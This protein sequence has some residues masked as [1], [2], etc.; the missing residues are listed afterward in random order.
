MYTCALY[1]IDCCWS[2][3]RFTLY[4]LNFSFQRYLWISIRESTV[5]HAIFYGHIITLENKA[6]RRIIIVK[7]YISFFF[8][9]AY[10]IFVRRGS[11]WPNLT[12]IPPDQHITLWCLLYTTHKNDFIYTQWH[13]QNRGGGRS[14]FRPTFRYISFM[15]GST[16]LSII[17]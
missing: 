7:K 8:C 13:G 14:V 4:F 11:S 10:E 1:R 15:Y 5:K 16:R 12:R 9:P 6:K 17:I 2:S 3:R